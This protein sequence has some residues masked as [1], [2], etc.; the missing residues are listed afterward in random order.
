MT[1]PS[2][3]KATLM[4]M[5]GELDKAIVA[6]EVAAGLSAMGMEVNMWFVLYG[7]N[8]LKKPTGLFS[9]RKWVFQ[10]KASPGRV[11]ETDVFM[12]R[13]VKL[14]NHDGADH[15]PLSQLNYFGIGP[16]ILNYIMRKKGIPGLHKLI[17]NAVELGVKFKICQTCIDALAIDVERDLIV[18]AHVLGVSSYAMDVKTS[19]FNAVY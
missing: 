13:M 15:L 12:Q 6:F 4:L 5:S 9:R 14:L 3:D 2:S 7:V 17:G 1:N 16:R 8:C 18:E 11:P 10:S 19:H